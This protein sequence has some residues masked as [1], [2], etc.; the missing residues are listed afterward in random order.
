MAMAF[1]NGGGFHGV[2]LV[3]DGKTLIVDASHKGFQAEV[4]VAIHAVD[5]VKKRL[6]G[7]TSQPPGR[8]TVSLQQPEG[9]ALFKS[10]DKVFAVA[11]ATSP[12]GDLFLWAD[13]F[14]IPSTN[15]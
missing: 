3:G 1:N 8:W 14:D 7:R 10:G 9:S 15:D 5:D 13:Q 12:K 2:K 11:Q 6:E 4:H